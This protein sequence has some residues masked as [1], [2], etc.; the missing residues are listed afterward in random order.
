M[1]GGGLDD[2]SV[3]FAFASRIREMQ[4][5]ILT[6]SSF[7]GKTQSKDLDQNLCWHKVEYTLGAFLKLL[8]IKVLSDGRSDIGELCEEAVDVCGG[9]G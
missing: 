3:L 2:E 7:L 6:F 5:H 8:W 1:D 4:R 9:R